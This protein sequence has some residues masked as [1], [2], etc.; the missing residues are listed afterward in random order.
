MTNCDDFAHQSLTSMNFYSFA[1]TAFYGIRCSMYQLSSIGLCAYDYS[2]SAGQI[3]NETRLAS[4]IDLLAQ[5]RIKKI[6][7]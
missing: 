3:G 5:E 7:V 2:Y 4:S 1:E 6:K